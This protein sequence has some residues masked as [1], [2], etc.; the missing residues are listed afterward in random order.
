MLDAKR[1]VIEAEQLRRVEERLLAAESGMN[2]DPE[3][4]SNIFFLE[5]D[6]A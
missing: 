5:E 2:E 1:R 6:A 3:T 4:D